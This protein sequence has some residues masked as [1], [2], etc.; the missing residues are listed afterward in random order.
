MVIPWQGH[1]AAAL[2]VG[3]FA[4]ALA[5]AFGDMHQRA[6]EQIYDY[7]GL[8][9]LSRFW[10]EPPALA[11]L[12]R[13][14][15]LGQVDQNSALL[16][17]LWMMPDLFLGS[18]LC[19][20]VLRLAPHSRHAVALVVVALPV[21]VLQPLTAAVVLGAAVAVLRQAGTLPAPGVMQRCV[22]AVAALYIGLNP[23]SSYTGGMTLEPW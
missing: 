22:L 11:A 5:T 8:T 21:F 12:A 9:W 6:S 13:E 14:F 7:G 3:L 19:L 2:V 23:S 17:Q 15:L 4:W 18:A 1:A 20:V 10:S 16:M